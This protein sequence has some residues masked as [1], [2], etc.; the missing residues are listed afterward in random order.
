MF[1]KGKDIFVFGQVF[2][3]ELFEYLINRFKEAF[4]HSSLSIEEAFKELDQFDLII[5]SSMN[6]ESNQY[7]KSLD[8]AKK[9]AIISEMH[10]MIVFKGAHF[11]VFSE[12]MD[13]QNIEELFKKYFSYFDPYLPFFSIYSE[14]G[15]FDKRATF[16]NIDTL[17][18]NL[19]Q[20][21]M[22]YEKAYNMQKDN[23]N[24]FDYAISLPEI[25][26][27]DV[28]KINSIVNESDDN[29]EVGFKRTNNAIFGATFTPVDK[30]NVPFE[31]QK[32]FA[33]YKEGF[34][35][36]IKDPS[37]AGIT[38]EEKYE[39][40]CN[41]F[42]REAIFHIRFERIHP[43][44]DGNGRT[45][46]ILMNYNLLNQGLAP[47]LITGIMAHDYRKLINDYDVEGL[48]KMLLNSSSQQ[49]TNWVSIG[50][51][52]TS[53]RKKD[54]NPTNEELAELLGYFDDEP[55]STENK[56]YLQLLKKLN[57]FLF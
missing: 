3:Y 24:A 13:D 16:R 52:H 8:S 32:L 2:P 57:L 41:L 44:T 47:V 30:K 7:F 39:R 20:R 26:I 15:E 27:R 46:R 54:I 49:I 22:A 33:E 56:P 18:Y 9:R 35:L 31:M 42:R 6:Q 51:V 12:A 40:T 43:F 48:A 53:I 50:K 1:E 17:F 34:G 36:D 55:H 38:P 10:K 21:K 4:S 37:E 23:L 29:H 19:P 28:I 11:G 45:G 14:D 5:N 25:T